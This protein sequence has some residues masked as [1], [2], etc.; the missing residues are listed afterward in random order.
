LHLLSR[1]DKEHR[2]NFVWIASA[3][4]FGYV[5][6]LDRGFVLDCSCIPICDVVRSFVWIA[7]A[8]PFGYVILFDKDS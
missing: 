3:E 2:Y 1:S 7:L 4:P 8:E 6:L 5:I